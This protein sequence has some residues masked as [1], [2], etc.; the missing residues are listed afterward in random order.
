MMPF[1]I[2]FDRGKKF[3]ADMRAKFGHPVVFSPGFHQKEFTLVVSFSRA[4]FK[5]DMHT[6]SV[7]LLAMFGAYA[8]GFRVRF[9]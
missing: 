2:N 9:L 8:Q 7:S 6:V 4:T 5:L 3:Q 1:V